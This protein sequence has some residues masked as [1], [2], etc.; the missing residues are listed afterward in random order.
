MVNL[1]LPPS[2]SAPPTTM[3]ALSHKRGWILTVQVDLDGFNW[4]IVGNMNE[5]W[6]GV[7]RCCQVGGEVFLTSASMWAVATAILCYC[8][9]AMV[10]SINVH[11]T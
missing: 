9:A 3:E 6:T 2:P 11:H 7:E 4:M 10:Y 5:L 8:T 1:M